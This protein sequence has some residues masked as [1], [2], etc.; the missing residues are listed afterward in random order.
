MPE[1]ETKQPTLE[2]AFKQRMGEFAELESLDIEEDGSLKPSKANARLIMASLN[3]S[4]LDAG[5]MAAV[6][7]LNALVGPHLKD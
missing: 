5:F 6:M 2:E 1:V 4:L 3:Q 7:T